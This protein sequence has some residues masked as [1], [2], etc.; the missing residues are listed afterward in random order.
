[1]P[2]F[3]VA[4][5]TLPLLGHGLARRWRRGLREPGA[6]DAAHLGQG[7]EMRGHCVAA[8]RRRQREG[9]Q[10]N[11]VHPANDEFSHRQTEAD[12]D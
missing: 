8:D 2:A 12:R 3:G 11:V 4:V 1:M 7:A 6:V 5:P 9:Q 10:G